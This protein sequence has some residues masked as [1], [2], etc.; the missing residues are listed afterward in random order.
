M[1]SPPTPLDMAVALLRE[2]RPI[3]AQELMV[4]ELQKI[5][6]EHGRGGPAWASAQ[7]DLGHVLL[8]SDQFDRAAECYRQACSGPVP[9]DQEHRKDQ[10]T[11]RLNLGM[12]LQHAGRLDEAADELRRNVQ[13][14]MAFYGREHAGYAFGLEALADVLYRRGDL[15]EA[16]EAA[17]ETVATFWRDGHERVAGAL[18]QRAE[19]L[20]AAGSEGPAFTGL[21]PL[22][23]EIIE[24]MALEAVN[25]IDRADPQTGAA[26]LTDLA[27]LL[28]ARLGPDHQATLNALSTLANLGHHLGDQ[29]MRIETIRR[30]LASYDRQGAHEQALMTVL[31]LA[32]AYGDAGDTDAGLHEYAQ[33]LARA[34]RIDR[35]EMTSQVLRNWGL[36]LKEAGRK[37]EAERRLREAVTEALRGADH[38]MLGRARIALGLFLQHE[39][40]LEEA[41]SIVSEALAG[42]DPAHPDAVVGRSHLGAIAE[43]RSC[44]CGDMGGA[45]AEAFRQFV[46][47]QLPAGLLSRFDVT[48]EDGD[49]K[50]QVELSREPEPEELERLDRV[51]QT[52]YADFRRRLTARV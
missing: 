13:E 22:P 42:M 6:R 20:K 8:N 39:E 17:E 36:A 11:Y 49:F 32:M 14:R 15:R 16:L 31:G 45:V 29:R 10:I 50:I 30:V 23:D 35:P 18:A 12:A 47:H 44:G 33:A 37:E 25:R 41:R 9:A 26:V 21:E 5:E 27:S 52:G 2:G 19:I 43:G 40:R 38:E 3:D 1:T 24:R 4:R 28:E 7:C 46:V 34:Q 51:I 48:V